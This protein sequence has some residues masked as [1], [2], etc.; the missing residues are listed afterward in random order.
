VTKSADENI[1][2]RPHT[3]V[4]GRPACMEKDRI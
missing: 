4:T 2:T 3:T 1:M